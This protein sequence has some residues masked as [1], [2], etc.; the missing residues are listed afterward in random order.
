MVQIAFRGRVELASLLSLNQNLEEQ[1]EKVEIL[2]R[3]WQGERVDLEILGFQSDANIRAA[4]QL[5]EA[6]KAPA[7]IEDEG[8]RVVLLEIRDQEVE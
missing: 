1:R 2:F 8:V 5:R 6:L 3:R 4:K 7:E